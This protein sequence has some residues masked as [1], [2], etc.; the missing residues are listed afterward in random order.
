MFLKANHHELDII[1]ISR[2]LV[3]ECYSITRC[4]PSEERF[5]LNSQIRR[6][7]ISVYLNVSEGCGRKSINERK[8]FFEI[9]RASVTEVDAAFDI[10]DDLGYCKNLDLKNLANYIQ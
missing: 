6:A 8:R 1:K 10:A 5:I 7:S 2:A 4:F 3:G 9:S